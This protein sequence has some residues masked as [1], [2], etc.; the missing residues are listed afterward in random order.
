MVEPETWRTQNGH[1]RSFDWLGEP[2]RN[3]TG[4]TRPSRL[5]DHR[6]SRRDPSMST[7]LPAHL[8]SKLIRQLIFSYAI[9]FLIIGILFIPSV[10]APWIKP[11]QRSF[12]LKDPTISHPYELNETVPSWSLH[13]TEYC[14][15]VC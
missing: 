1:C 13:V 2:Q 14:T 10:L 15:T 12:D 5:V 6:M 11:Y 7:D 4:W 9:D 8:K 3:E